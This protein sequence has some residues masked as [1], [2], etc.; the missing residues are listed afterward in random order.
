MSRDRDSGSGIFSEL[1]DF[2]Y[3]PK[4]AA[5]W[6]KFGCQVTIVAAVVIGLQSLDGRGCGRGWQ[7][8]QPQT[9][10]R[11]AACFVRSLVQNVPEGFEEGKAGG[12]IVAP[13][14]QKSGGTVA[15]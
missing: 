11:P 13:P 6:V 14:T 10:T 3:D 2:N 7:F 15:P 9:W 5:S 4:S 8:W 1:A 12:N